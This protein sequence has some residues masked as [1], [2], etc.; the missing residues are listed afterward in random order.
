MR[1]L[2]F[3]PAGALYSIMSTGNGSHAH[4]FSPPITKLFG[5]F[6]DMTAGSITADFAFLVGAASYI[7]LIIVSPR[8]RLAKDFVPG[9]LILAALYFVLPNKMASGS[10]VD[11]RLP[12]A[13]VLLALS[14]LD[15]QFRGS[16]S[17]TV[18]VLIALFSFAF[19]VKQLAVTVLWRSFTAR[20]LMRS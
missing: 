9:L 14:G 3:L 4:D 8:R 15:V 18:R 1:G 11:S 10:Y 5:L 16:R 6:K 2:E 12:I 7:L 19:V 17:T 20:R 13:V